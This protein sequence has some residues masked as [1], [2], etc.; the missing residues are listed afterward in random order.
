MKATTTSPLAFAKA[1][2]GPSLLGE[3]F[4][5]LAQSFEQFCLMAR[6]NSF[7]TESF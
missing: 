4:K 2:R 7:K 5:T 1:P 6:A 3:A